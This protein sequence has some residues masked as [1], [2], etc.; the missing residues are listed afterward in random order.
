MKKVLK[1]TFIILFLNSHNF[2]GWL[3]VAYGINV[4]SIPKYYILASYRIPNLW[5]QAIPSANRN[6]LRKKEEE[7]KKKKALPMLPYRIVLIIAG[8]NSPSAQL[9]FK[10]DKCL[11]LVCQTLNNYVTCQEIKIT[12]S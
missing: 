4:A 7:K 1:Y 12:K 10:T 3:F 2:W 11:M 5:Y 9:K 6:T 8:H